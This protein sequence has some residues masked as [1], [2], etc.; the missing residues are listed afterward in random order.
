MET[1][2]SIPTFLIG[3][4]FNGDST[5]LE[6]DELTTAQAIDAMYNCVDVREG[7]YFDHFHDADGILPC[8]CVEVI[9]FER[10]TQ[11]KATRQA[12]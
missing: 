5:G 2:L 6:P 9:A 4:L 7:E 1:R 8:Q 12:V 10:E 11:R 3:Y